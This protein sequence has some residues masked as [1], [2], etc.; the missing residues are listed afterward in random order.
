M[1]STATLRFRSEEEVRATLHDAGFR[2]EALWGGWQREPV[3]QGDGELL[4]VA[5]RV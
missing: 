4:V 3:G 1:I 2:V 5:R